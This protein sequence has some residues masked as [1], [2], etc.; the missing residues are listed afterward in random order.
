MTTVSTSREL[1]AVKV[2]G[3]RERDEDEK[4]KEGSDNILCDNKDNGCE[5]MISTG[6]SMQ[7]Y[8]EGFR[9]SPGGSM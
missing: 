9:H 6:S 4:R 7:R 3:V 2:Q 1:E 8:R 5:L